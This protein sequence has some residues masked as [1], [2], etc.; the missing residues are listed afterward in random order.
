MEKKKMQNI[1]LLETLFS[2]TNYRQKKSDTSDFKIA[3]FEFKIL[4]TFY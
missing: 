1:L 4:E 3:N 2:K